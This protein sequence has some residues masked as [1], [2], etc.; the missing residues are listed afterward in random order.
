M[1]F[2]ATCFDLTRPSSV[3]YQLEEI[4]TMYG[5]TRQYYHAVTARHRIWE[6]YAWTSLNIKYVFLKFV[7]AMQY[8]NLLTIHAIIKA[9]CL[10]T[11]N[12]R[13]IFLLPNTINEIMDLKLQCLPPAV[14]VLTEFDPYS[15]V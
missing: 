8:N 2:L 3:K 12:S 11:Y 5:L 7:F 9:A 6:I 15:K 4:T 1:S 14:S 10:T 13:Q